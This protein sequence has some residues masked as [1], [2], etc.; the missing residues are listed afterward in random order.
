[1]RLWTIPPNRLKLVLE[2]P[3]AIERGLGLGLGLELGLVRV[4]QNEYEYY[5]NQNLSQGT[6]P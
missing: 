5:S 4:M 1:M 3:H 6:I 2:G